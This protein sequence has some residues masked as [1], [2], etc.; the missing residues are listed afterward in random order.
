[1]ANES[2]ALDFANADRARALPGT[3]AATIA[4]VALLLLVFVGL[5]AF[6]PPAEVSEFG[7]ATS[8]AQ[9]DLLRQILYLSAF[10]VSVI[11]AVQRRG[12]MAVKA[13]P[14]GMALLLL[15]CLASSRWAAVPDIALRRAGLEMVLTLSVLFSV[16]TIGAERAFK[17][18]RILLAVVLVVN[19]ISI[20]LI[21]QARHL[22]GEIDPALVGNWRGLYG[23]K[24]IA[25]AV[26]V[27]TAL[28]FLFTQNG[29]RNWIGVAVAILA[30]G[31]LVMTHSKTSLGFLPLAIFAGILY[32]LGWRDSLSRSLLTAVAAFV[33]LGLA[34]FAILDADAIARVLEDPAEFTGRAAIW[35]AEIAYIRDHPLLGAG[36][37]TFAD[38]G[39]YSPLRDYINGSWVGVVSHGHNGY[40]QLVVTTGLIGFV[41]AIST[42]I[43][44]PL[45]RFWAL[46]RARN[47][48]KPLLFALFIFLMLHN[49]LESDFLEGDGVA[50][51]AFVLVVAAVRQT[52]RPRANA[53]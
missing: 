21:P 31:F 37:G 6:Q 5:D 23:H 45:V 26:C 1:M 32:R 25:G 39:T 42:L 18:W 24:N 30:T 34:L 40:L 52:G 51:V 17:L 49:F 7:G 29:K 50:W 3:L 47:N 38:T 4:F 9:G 46:D 2:F 15:W 12:L 43:L 41:L 10:A 13:I 48:F 8:L 11:C 36:F 27:M 28:L 33:L 44:S 14:L 53:L 19:W 16:D 35:A 22:A 20:P